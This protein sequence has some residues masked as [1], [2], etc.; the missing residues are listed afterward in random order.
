VNHEIAELIK[1]ITQTRKLDRDFVVGA[2]R[3]AIAS[4]IRKDRGPDYPVEVGV[5]PERGEIMVAIE[6][7]IVETVEDPAYEIS[8]E[9]AKEINPDAIVGAPCKVQV[10]FEKFG[11]GV[12]YRIQ[13]FFLQ[14]IRDAERQH[15]YKDFQE[16]TGE[17]ITGVIQKVDKTGVYVSL[18]RAEALLSPEEQIPGEKYKQGGNIRAI[19]LKVED[20]RKRRSQIMLSRTHPDFLRKLLEFEIPEVMEG[21]VEVRAV[22]RMPGRRAKI[23]VRSKDSRV[24]AVGAC[25]GVRGTRIQPVVREL[26]G[27]KIDVIRWNPDL[28]RFAAAAISPADATLVYEEDGQVVVV[29]PD[30]EIQDAMGKEGQNVILASRL[31]GKEIR[32]VAD[33]E[34]EGPKEGV[35]VLE[36]K[37]I[38]NDVKE[39]L[40]RSGFY[41]F[42][43]IPALAELLSV[44]GLTESIAYRILEG[45]EAKLEEKGT[46]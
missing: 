7:K 35:S 19:I 27:E 20:E 6:K 14:R 4:A 5:Y 15:I 3:E 22:S 1:Q 13:H 34:H 18:G 43:E 37:G 41:V 31:V 26:M 10:P 25:I 2:L 9:E 38:G 39:Q 46:E 8:F 45:V 44:E 28:V 42:K 21:T 11:R 29:V 40:R 12:I 32:L 30:G 16:R 33:G 23:A 24:D 17:I 36:L